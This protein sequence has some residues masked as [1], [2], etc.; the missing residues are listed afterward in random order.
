MSFSNNI[1]KFCAKSNNTIST[2]VRKIVIDMGTA[3]ILRTPVGNPT[4]WNSAAPA[5][6]VGGAARANWQYSVSAMRQGILPD[7]DAS[8][9]N[10]ITALVNGVSGTKAE[11]VH[12]IS[13]NL[14][15]IQRLE[16]GWSYKQA[17]Q[18]ML[19]LTV[20]EFKETVESAAKSL[21]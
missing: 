8:G 11:S 7:T 6:Y 20:L 4:L 3:L 13:N 17:P 14:P 15:Y 1:N 2:V 12:W 5:N 19:R 18:G 21:R 16:N 9:Q 10:T